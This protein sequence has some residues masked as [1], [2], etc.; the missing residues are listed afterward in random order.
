VKLLKTL[1][2]PDGAK[3]DRG[4]PPLDTRETVVKLSQQ[5]WAPVEIARVTSISLGEV[6]L[7]LELAP[8]QK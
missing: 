4:A 8:Q 5:G 2:K 3:K 6:E 7:I 1:V